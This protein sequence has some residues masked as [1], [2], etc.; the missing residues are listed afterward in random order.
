MQNRGLI[1][2]ID[3][4]LIRIHFL[5]PEEKETIEHWIIGEDIE[6]DIVSKF[7]DTYTADLYAMK[8]FESGEQKIIFMKKNIWE[9]TK[10]S[11]HC[12]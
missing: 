12:K 7:K 6:E 5:N 2:P 9:E 10:L 11:M 3:K 4:D 8:Y 1:K